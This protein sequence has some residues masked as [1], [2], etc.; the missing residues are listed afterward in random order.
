[1]V[2]AECQPWKSLLLDEHN[3]EEIGH[4]WSLLERLS[5][6]QGSSS[7]KE[8]KQEAM[9]NQMLMISKI[10]ARVVCGDG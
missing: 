3:G 8:L 1:M 7:E 9:R 4:F 5:G 10:S 2:E 6:A